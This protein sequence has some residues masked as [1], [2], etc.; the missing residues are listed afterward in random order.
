MALRLGRLLS[1]LPSLFIFSCAS[2]PQKL[3]PS[4]FYKRD[5]ELKVNG[6]L[7]KGVVITPRATS[8]SLEIKAPG[9]INLFT[10]TT[11]H[12]EET[13]EESGDGQ[14][15]R[16]FSFIPNA[17]ES[18]KTACPIQLGGYER[19]QGRHSWGFIDFEHPG[20]T[21]LADVNCNGAFKK[22]KGV[23]ACQAKAGLIQE[24]AFK[25][26]VLWP[27]KST[28]IKIESKDEKRIRFKMPKGECSVRFVTKSGPEQWH[29]ITL[30]GYEKILIR[31]N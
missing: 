16:S 18:E 5:M 15:E 21:L 8:Y 2:V 29:R 7:S 31:E 3:D 20:M 6:V 14:H 27:L 25:V 26:K 17:L 1:F 12:R 10:L 11:C 24:I 13:F 23:S 4:I 22:Y 30:L 9:K 19:I 28:C